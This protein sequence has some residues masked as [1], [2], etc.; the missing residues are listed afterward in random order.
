ME[1]IVTGDNSEFA[2]LKKGDVYEEILLVSFEGTNSTANCT[3]YAAFFINCEKVFGKNSRNI[4]E[5]FA[6][7]AR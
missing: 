4:N 6:V 5:R 2:S 7:I 3:Y 1:T